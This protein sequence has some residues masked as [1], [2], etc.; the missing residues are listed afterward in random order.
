MPKE[1]SKSA[2]SPEIAIQQTWMRA[3]FRSGGPSTSAPPRW[4]NWES[5]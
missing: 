4:R 2:V 1:A 3:S 5:A